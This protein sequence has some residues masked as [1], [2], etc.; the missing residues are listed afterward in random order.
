MV[1]TVEKFMFE[2]TYHESLDRFFWSPM[3]HTLCHT[4]KYYPWKYRKVCFLIFVASYP[5]SKNIQLFLYRNLLIIRSRG[6]KWQPEAALSSLF[7]CHFNREPLR[8]DHP[9]SHEYCVGCAP[10]R[11]CGLLMDW[12]QHRWRMCILAGNW[13]RDVRSADL[14]MSLRRCQVH[15]R[16]RFGLNRNTVVR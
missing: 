16:V 11:C 4:R 1:V 12:C 14:R 3:N 13:R 2:N 5:S 9:S 7:Y 10:V 15:A 8:S 6:Y